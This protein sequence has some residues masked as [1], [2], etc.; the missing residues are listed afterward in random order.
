MNDE[1]AEIIGLRA[2]SYIA[3]NEEILVAYLKLTGI[4]PHELKESASEPVILGSILD[5]FLQNE[6]RLIAFCDDI[7][8][9]P[10]QIIHARRLLPGGEIIINNI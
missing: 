7:N 3:Q 2:L 10:N 9:M 6:K 1:Q 5:Y 8:M 4:T